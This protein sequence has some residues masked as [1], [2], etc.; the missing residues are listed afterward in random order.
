MGVKFEFGWLEIHVYQ[1]FLQ[2]PSQ[3]KTPPRF[4]KEPAG[5]TVVKAPAYDL[6]AVSGFGRQP[7]DGMND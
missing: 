6:H 2:E 4:Q 5:L 7:S 3:R 1:Q